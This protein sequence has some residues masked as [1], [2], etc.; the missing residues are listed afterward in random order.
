MS[1]GLTFLASIADICGDGILVAPEQCDGSDFGGVDCTGVGNFVGGTLQCTGCCAYDTSQCLTCGNNAVCRSHTETLSSSG[2]GVLTFAELNGGSTVCPGATIT[3]SRTNVGCGNVGT[4]GVTVTINDGITS[5]SCV[6]SVTVQDLTNPVINSCPSSSTINTDTNQCTSTAGFGTATASDACGIASIVP[7]PAAPYG[8]GSR[9]VTWTATDSNGLSATCSHSLTVVD[10]QAPAI[11]CPGASTINT[12][13]GVCTSTAGFGPATATDNCGISQ[14]SA[15][16]SYPYS[17]GATTV[18][19]TALDD[20][21]LSTP[22]SHQLTVVDNENPT[23]TC[24]ADETYPADVGRCDYSGSITQATFG[25]NCGASLSQSPS[26][27]FPLGSTTVVWTATDAAGNSASCSNVVTI[28]DTQVPSFLYCPPD[29]TLDMDPGVCTTTGDIGTPMITDNCPSS[30]MT[31]TP[32]APFPPFAVTGPVTIPVTHT[33]HD[34]PA[35]NTATCVQQ[36]TTRDT[37]DPVLTMPSDQT[38]TLG[39]GTHQV[40]TYT[41]PTCFDNCQCSVSHVSGPLTGDALLPGSYSVIYQATDSSGRVSQE[42][43]SIEINGVAILTPDPGS[44]DGTI[45]MYIPRPIAIVSHGPQTDTHI[46]FDFLHTGLTT[47][48]YSEVTPVE[49]T[50]V[51]V[52]G[53]EPDM[54]DLRAT[55]MQTGITTMGPTIRLCTAEWEGGPCAENV[56]FVSN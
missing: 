9:T 18:T 11:T 42:T 54:Y 15:S 25:D 47:V 29:L 14:I 34:T 6:A 2:S 32:V 39:S 22:C 33:A 24:P 26:G 45:Y 36:I 38:Y 5:D 56:P 1:H 27:T 44:G 40:I 17:L 48:G 43:F 19:W 49:T 13:A 21:G 37:Q 50:V 52:F 55:G 7:S 30:F 51:T 16:P 35:G 28:E 41:T 10:N 4:F 31:Q 23:I 20:N 12:D 53:T 3:L 8:V 46:R